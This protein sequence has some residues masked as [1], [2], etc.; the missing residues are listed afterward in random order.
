MT[1][2]DT[3]KLLTVELKQWAKDQ[4]KMPD[5]YYRGKKQAYNDVLD[6]LK[7]Q[8][9]DPRAEAE[10]VYAE[11][12]RISLGKGK[13]VKDSSSKEAAAAREAA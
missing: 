2:T 12:Y 3:L 11:V 1:T 5:D 13:W 9:T 6:W 8:E 4:D 10:A 7:E